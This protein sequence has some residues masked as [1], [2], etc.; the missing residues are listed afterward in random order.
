MRNRQQTIARINDYYRNVAYICKQA[1][2]I[3]GLLPTGGHFFIQTHL[4]KIMESM[5][6]K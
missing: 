4:F 5:S 6:Y 3:K 2:L 1:S